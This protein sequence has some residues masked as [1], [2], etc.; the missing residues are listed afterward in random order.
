MLMPVVRQE[1]A[2]DGNRTGGNQP[3]HQSMS[4]DV[5]QARL[6]PCT[7]SSPVRTTAQAGDENLCSCLLKA[8]IRAIRRRHLAEGDFAVMEIG[9]G[10]NA[11]FGSRAGPR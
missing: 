3:A 7:T 4:T 1:P 6:L 5:Q 11:D 9:H 2:P 10:R 8:D